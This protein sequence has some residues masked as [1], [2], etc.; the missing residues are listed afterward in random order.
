MKNLKVAIALF[1]I[2]SAG[3]VYSQG[4]VTMKSGEEMKSQVS[5]V[6]GDGGR[7]KEYADPLGLAYS[8]GIS[9]V[10]VIEHK[11]G[12]EDVFVGDGT[13]SEE[14]SIRNDEYLEIEFKP[15]I[16]KYYEGSQVISK[17]EFLRRMESNPMAYRQYR[18]GKNLDIASNVIGIPAGLVFG[19]ILGTWIFSGDK[20]DETV[21]TVSGLCSGGA[22]ALAYVGRAKIIKSVDTYNASVSLGLKLN[23]N[24]NG[25]GL[26][27]QF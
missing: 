5:E 26:A 11:N 17:K 16:N 1:L 15:F 24:E 8:I 4:I 23:I 2:Y 27:F 3:N 22:I 19:H 12:G 21:L 7:H 20:P 18:L 10:S 13:K 6:S 9:E 25:I 14:D